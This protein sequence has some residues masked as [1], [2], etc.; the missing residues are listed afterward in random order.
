MPWIIFQIN[1]TKLIMKTIANAKINHPY[2][3]SIVFNEKIEN[4]KNPTNVIKG[5][6]CE[7]NERFA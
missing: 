7:N 3:V 6:K 5:R 4:S 2:V 1:T